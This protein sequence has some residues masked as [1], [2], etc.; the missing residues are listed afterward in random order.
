MAKKPERRQTS[1]DDMLNSTKPE[2]LRFVP[3][4]Y[5]DDESFDAAKVAVA[6]PMGSIPS[7]VETEVTKTEETP[8]EP[9]KAPEKKASAE[10]K[11]DAKPRKTAKSPARSASKMNI[12]SGSVG[13]LTDLILSVKM[14]KKA[15]LKHYMIDA[16][17]AESLENYVQLLKK[18]GAKASET[19]IVN[20]ILRSFFNTQDSPA[21]EDDDEV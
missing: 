10:K 6:P 1:L 11:A 12:T 3:P 5:Q 8:K 7:P 2:G 18:Q 21:V 14:P 4:A 16:D 19:F 15:S 17:V 9:E 13:E 20:T